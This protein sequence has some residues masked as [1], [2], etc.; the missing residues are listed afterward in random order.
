MESG[1]SSTYIVPV[2]DKEVMKHS[3]RRV[4]VGGRLLTKILT[5]MISVRQYKMEGYFQTVNKIKEDTCY[6]EKGAANI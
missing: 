6:I 5:Q 3:I 2:F 4:D 1:H